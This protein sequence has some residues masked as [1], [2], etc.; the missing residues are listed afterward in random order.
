MAPKT[1]TGLRPQAYEHPSDT[2][3]L[4]ALTRTAGLDTLVRKLNSWGFERLLRVQLTGSYLRATPDSMSDLYEWLVTARE[5][6]D[7]PMLPDLYVAGSGELNAITAGVDRPL[8]LLY[9]GAVEQ[10]TPYEVQFVIA[11]EL[12]HIKSGHVLYY[13]IAEFLPVIAGVIGTVTLGIGDLLST[14]LQVAL[15]HWKRMSEFTADRA[16]LL[17]CQDADVAMRT[18]MK[19]AGLPPRYYKSINTEDFLRQAREF[20][21]MDTETLNKIAKWFSTMG[22]TH[23]WTVMRA[24]QLLLWVDRGGYEEVLKAPQRIAVKLP[25]GVQGYCQQCGWPYRVAQAF[26]SGCGG[27]ITKT[28]T[29]GN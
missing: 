19:L 26:C 24:Q 17:A 7:V 6:L 13:Q 3:T 11:H 4:N 18:L 9:S 14:G 21:A 16:G 23:P 20:E 15:L 5:R 10:L 1:L 8:I 12:G 27:A 25:E 2:A 29:A 28:A 22:A